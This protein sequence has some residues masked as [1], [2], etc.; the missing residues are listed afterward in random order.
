MNARCRRTVCLLAVAMA[1]I[2]FTMPTHP[3]IAPTMADVAFTIAY[4]PPAEI[5]FTMPTHPP[6]APTAVAFTMPTHPPIAP[7]A[8][9]FTMPH[10]PI[11]PTA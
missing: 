2:G 4:P 3:P 8:V 10:P 6:I 1:T 7:T 5:A 9:A 11:A